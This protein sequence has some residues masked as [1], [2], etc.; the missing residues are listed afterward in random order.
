MKSNLLLSYRYVFSLIMGNYELRE[1]KT[2]T[3]NVTWTKMCKQSF[4]KL[5]QK[6]TLF[7]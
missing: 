6:A 2:L 7:S 5:T 3:F 4:F 1:K